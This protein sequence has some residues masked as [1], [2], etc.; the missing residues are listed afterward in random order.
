MKFSVKKGI[1][2]TAWWFYDEQAVPKGALRED[3]ASVAPSDA[4]EML[5]FTHS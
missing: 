1:K 4:F 5:K 2:W 3:A